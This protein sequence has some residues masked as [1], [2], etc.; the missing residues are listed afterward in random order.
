MDYENLSKESQEFIRSCVDTEISM[1]DA[2]E[3]C[4]ELAKND[5]IYF[6]EEITNFIDLDDFI[7]YMAE[8][9]FEENP[10][11]SVH[12]LANFKLPV[13]SHFKEE[14]EDMAAEMQYRE[15]AHG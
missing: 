9:A 4:K 6:Y 14:L 5:P 3:F 10:P 7:G 1:R 8:T 12:I 11:Q 13:V 2:S 15:S